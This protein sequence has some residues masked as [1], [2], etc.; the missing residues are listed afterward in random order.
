MPKYKFN[1]RTDRNTRPDEP[2]VVRFIIRWGG[3]MLTYPTGETIAPRYWCNA[4]DQRNHQ[5]AKETKAF[6]EHP[7]FNERLDALL[8]TAKATF[9]KFLTDHDREP[10]PGELKAALDVANGRTRRRAPTCWGSSRPTCKVRKAGSTAPKETVPLRHVEPVPRHLELL[11]NTL[12]DGSSAKPRPMHFS[13]VDAEFVAG[14]TVFLTTEKKFAANTVVKYGK[15]L[16]HFLRRARMGPPVNEQVF[17]RNLSLREEPSEQI[18]LNEDE[19]SAFYRLDLQRI[20]H[21][22]RARDLFI[23]G[24]W[25][26]LRFGDLSRLQPEHVEGDRIR[27]PTAKTGKE[28]RIPLHPFVRAIMAKYGGKVP[29]GISNQKQNDYLKDAAALVPAL[30]TKIMVGGT[31]AGVRREVARAKWQM[32]T[33]HTARRSFA[34]NLYR[35]GVPARTI[36]AVTGH[37]TEQ[38]FMRYIRLSNDEHMDIIAA[39]PMFSTPVLKAV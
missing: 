2:A 38:V 28:V 36:M 13:A 34:T 16:R 3:N 33:T 5:R 8:S 12:P 35:G 1:L 22:E 14:F 27:I 15:T 21:L 29:S 6:P 31:K 18:Y 26:G 10:E 4:P 37:T 23:V 11:R 20:P 19:L 24:A 9:R 17:G 7:E 39:S 32:V 30:Q 25:T